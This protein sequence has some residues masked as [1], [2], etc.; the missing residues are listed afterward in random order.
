MVTL[1]SAAARQYGLKQ[2]PYPIWFKTKT[3]KNVGMKIFSA[4]AIIPRTFIFKIKL[5]RDRLFCCYI[6]AILLIT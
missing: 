3:I 5:E 1:G 6:I 2:N 4:I